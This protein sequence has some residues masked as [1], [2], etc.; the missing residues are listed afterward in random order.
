MENFE[1]S[2]QLNDRDWVEFY[3]ASEECSLIQA[4]LAT[5]EDPLPSDLED[6][7]VGNRLARVRV[8][9]GPTPSP[10]SCLPRG[11]EEVLSGSE[12]EADLGSV[13]RF[14]CDSDSQRGA[15][16]PQP[17][18][19]QGSQ[20]SHVTSELLG[21]RP[22]RPELAR[23][24]EASFA[25]E[26][27]ETETGERLTESDHP[28]PEVDVAVQKAEFQGQIS[29]LEA[30]EKPTSSVPMNTGASVGIDGQEEEHGSRPLGL[31]H[32]INDIS[33]IASVD[34]Q[35]P[36]PVGGD[37]V[38]GDPESPE[39]KGLNVHSTSSGF[40]SGESEGAECPET[41]T[42]NLRI[43]LKAEAPSFQE[44]PSPFQGLSV[45]L[46]T[47]GPSESHKEGVLESGNKEEGNAADLKAEGQRDQGE[48]LVDSIFKEDVQVEQEIS[49][50]GRR[51][52]LQ[53]VPE[54]PGASKCP[55]PTI[56]TDSRCSGT[57][58]QCR[59]TAVWKA[60]SQKDGTEEPCRHLGPVGPHEEESPSI[61]RGSQRSNSLEGNI[62]YCLA[63]ENSPEGQF[64]AT[65]WPQDY[66][67]FICGNTEEQAGKMQNRVVEKRSASDVG[68]DLP[69][70]YG[71]DM[72]EYFFA[73]VE[74]A[75][76]GEIGVEKEMGLEV[77]RNSDQPLAPSTGS[78]DSG[79]EGCGTMH[80]SVPEVYEHFFNN[81]AQGR[82]S[83]KRRFLSLPATE[84]RKAVRALKSL[85]SKPAHLLRCGP[86]R[87]GTPLRRGSHGKLVVFS[88]RLLEESQPRP[89]DLRM[90]MMS[91]GTD[92]I[93][94]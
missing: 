87:L 46:G 83:W 17:S 35:F 57:S 11:T 42:E 5:A 60:E 51:V 66:D 72:Y 50:A 8:G 21:G 24:C 2:I 59:E 53:K 37:T 86:P 74:G 23:D 65:T 73:D 81:G 34:I 27:R 82:K 1:Y 56:V 25:V 6:G 93:S 39:L 15:A 55:R 14:L 26:G 54:E 71:P 45:P 49:S 43:N 84:A 91:P 10:A 90:A 80:I 4:A 9:P 69:E 85:L 92:L 28:L 48:A 31:L 41:G 13:S 64:S 19:I 70:M 58:D 36:L 18:A 32:P 68:Q 29:G 22:E 79:S 47:L 75:W 30:M 89:E 33:Q 78:L 3:L 88:P 52:N 16:F 76:V 38:C 67:C 40:P 94:T 77:S 62:L 44:K 61:A 7:E 63:L 20:S 12:D